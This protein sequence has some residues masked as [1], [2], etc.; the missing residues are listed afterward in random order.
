MDSPGKAAIAKL[1]HMLQVRYLKRVEF[2]R[3]G[4]SFPLTAEKMP[5]QA[6]EYSIMLAHGCEKIHKTKGEKR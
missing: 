2:P 3:E 4:K 5:I 6:T 1:C